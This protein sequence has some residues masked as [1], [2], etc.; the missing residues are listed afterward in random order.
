MIE[1]IDRRY[2]IKFSD[3]NLADAFG[4]A[5]IGLA[6]ESDQECEAQCQREV[7]RGIKY[8]SE[9]P[10]RKVRRQ[11]VRMLFRAT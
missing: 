10:P 11:K 3:D 4:L 8:P 9:R 7:I 6:L 2:G 1:A 5:Q